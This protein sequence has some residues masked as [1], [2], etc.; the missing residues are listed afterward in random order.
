MSTNVGHI[1]WGTCAVGVRPVNAQ[2]PVFY[3]SS[4]FHCTVTIVPHEFI[5]TVRYVQSAKTQHDKLR[6]TS[7][8]FCFSLSSIYTYLYHP[9]RSASAICMRKYEVN[10]AQMPHIWKCIEYN[11]RQLAS[12]KIAIVSGCEW[13]DRVDAKIGARMHTHTHTLSFARW[14]SFFAICFVISATR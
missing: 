7:S 3:S 10:N 9:H 1:I 8:R 5:C 4:L 14:N 12:K 13:F 11:S 2:K 6:K